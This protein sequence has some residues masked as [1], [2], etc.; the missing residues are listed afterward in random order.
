MEKEKIKIRTIKGSEEVE[1]EPEEKRNYKTEYNIMQLFVLQK[2]VDMSL[3][4]IILSIDTNKE[5]IFDFI[6]HPTI[7]K[8]LNN[9]KSMWKFN[10][11][12]A[13]DALILS[14]TE[15]FYENDIDMND[16]NEELFLVEFMSEIR[17]KVKKQMCEGYSEKERVASDWDT[18]E[19]FETV[20]FE[21]DIVTKV[22]F[23]NSIKNLSLRDKD[24]LKLY[25][26]D[27]Y[28][29]QEISERIQLSQKQIS[30]I[31]FNSKNN[32]KNIF[33]NY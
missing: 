10:K 31:L 3:K 13:E 23:I 29:Q 17:N 8:L 18:Y 1:I 7:A 20:P 14:I 6:K 12:E 22:D 5:Y 27:K 16:F 4:E 2:S 30:N 24:V 15:Y 19:D 28:T 26:I 11:D 9:I 21:D 33:I 32:L 25:Y